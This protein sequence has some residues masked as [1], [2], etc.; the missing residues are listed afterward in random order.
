M[1]ARFVRC[2]SLYN[3]VIIESES[4]ES[5][6]SVNTVQGDF[7]N[8]ALQHILS[9]IRI[10]NVKSVGLIRN[11]LVDKV[12]SD[13]SFIAQNIGLETSHFIFLLPYEKPPS[14]SLTLSNEYVDSFITSPN[15][16]LNNIPDS[17]ETEKLCYRFAENLISN[18]QKV[19]QV[20]VHQLQ[21]PN[22]KI[23]QVHK[24]LSSEI[25]MPHKGDIEELKV[26]ID[27]LNKQSVLVDQV[28]VC[29]DE[30]ISDNHYTLHN[31]EPQVNFYAAIPD[32]LGPYPAR[33]VLCRNSKNELLIFHDSDDISTFDRVAS[34]QGAFQKDDVDAVGSHEL[35][36]NKLKERIEAC[37]LPLDVNKATD[38]KHWFNIFFPTTAIK[39]SAYLKVGGLSTV[40]RHSSDAQFYLKA[41]FYLR[42]ANLDQFCY[43]RVQRPNSLTTA[44][45]T[46]M[47]NIVRERLHSRWAYDFEK[48]RTSKISIEESSLV[49]EQHM[50]YFNLVPLGSNND[51]IAKYQSGWDEIKLVPFFK[52][53]APNLSQA[54]EKVNQ[55]RI[56]FDSQDE[57]LRTHMAMMDMNKSIMEMKHSYSWKIGQMSTRLIGR[58]FGWIPY[59]KRK[60]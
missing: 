56:T 15:N 24:G 44:E 29:F 40:R 49:D 19:Q 36:I 33:D 21:H 3:W 6:N 50:G 9:L 8:E 17:F 35:R 46:G 32:G 52:E 28:S 39:K 5:K 30:S 54:N 27:Y 12:E 16:F 45:D 53:Q 51:E 1:K 38:E 59:V 47:R 57:D 48:I 43:I 4:P 20:A 14:H 2:N 23:D 31:E 41:H 25:V 55:D 60:I 10:G 11:N 34:L 13:L 26:A 18:K 42:L 58:F 7:E 22:R 37:R